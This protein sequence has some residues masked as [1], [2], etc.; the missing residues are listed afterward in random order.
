MG[1]T[2]FLSQEAVIGNWGW[3]IENHWAQYAAK[4]WPLL[5][6]RLTGRCHV[7]VE[8]SRVSSVNNPPFLCDAVCSQ[9]TVCNLVDTT[10]I[11]CGRVYVTVW[12]PSVCLSQLSTAAAA[13]GGF[14][15]VYPAGRSY[16]W[17][18]AWPAPSS[19]G[20]AARRTAAR[21]SAAN[22]SSVTFTAAVER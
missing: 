16:Q 5:L 20:A 19:N 11:V 15:A 22:A 1:S 7:E 9:I 18:A 8:L 2:P 6:V 13:C 14:A 3:T 17:I 10:R 4:R 12:R 21:R